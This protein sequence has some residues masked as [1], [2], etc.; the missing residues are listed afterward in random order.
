MSASK[1]DLNNLTDDQKTQAIKEFRALLGSESP[2]HDDNTLLRFLIA[3]QLNAQK[4]HEMLNGY[5]EWREKEGIDRLPVP[6][7]NGNPVMQNVRGFRSVPDANWDMSVEG[8]PEDFKKFYSCMGGGCFHKVDKEGTPVFIERTGY[9]DVKGLAVK[10]SPAVMLDWH[11]RNNE[12]VFNV[13]MPECTQ[14]A[15]KT[16]EKHTVIFDCT[17]LGIWQFDM[18][19]LNLLRAVSDLDSRVY[20]ERLGKLFIVNTPG[21]FARAWNIIKRWLDKRILEKIFICGSD[22][23]DVLLQHVDAENLPDF[24]GGKCTCSHMPGG[25]VPSPYLESRNAKGAGDNF[26]FSTSLGSSSH[27][28]EITVPKE[29]VEG[30]SQAKLFYKF[31]TTKRAVHFEIRHRKEDCAD[32]RVIVPSTSRDSHKEIVQSDMNVEPGTYVF[33]WQKPAGGFSLFNS[34]ALDYSIDLTVEDGEEFVTEHVTVHE[35]DEKPGSDS[36]DVVETAEGV[37][38]LSVS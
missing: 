20:P 17:G 30:A 37:G 5:F 18:T 11:I 21:I 4:A 23:K 16:I 28:Y 10:C 1:I 35:A 13:L 36:D 19:G 31:R 6:G 33:S 14:R 24:L 27:E 7:V 12:F 25:C 3:R 15:G 38:R 32:E 29:E 22:Y 2:K 9:H 26:Q 8:M 34:L